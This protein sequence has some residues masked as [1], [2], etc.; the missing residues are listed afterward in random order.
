LPARP[1]RSF[2]ATES[3]RRNA[4]RRGVGDVEAGEQRIGG[5][6]DARHV[7][8]VEIE[9]VLGEGVELR[10]QVDGGDAFHD[11]PLRQVG[12]VG[13]L[14]RDAEGGRGEAGQA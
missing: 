2:L 12:R 9:V 11:G 4:C 1:S 13:H 14:R 8:A 3:L 7:A 10:Q 5:I 6:A